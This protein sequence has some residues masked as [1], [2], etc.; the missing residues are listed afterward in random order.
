MSYKKV[1]KINPKVVI[2]KNKRKNLE[3]ASIQIN[4]IKE[5]ATVVYVDEFKY[6]CHKSGIYGWAYKGKSGN[7][8]LI[9]G[10]FQATLIAVVSAKK[11]HEVL[12]TTKTIDSQ[13]FK[14]FLCKL[15]QSIDK[16][17]VIVCDNSKVH[18]SKLIRDFLKDYKLW[19]ITIP[20][21]CPWVNAWE[22]LILNIKTW[23]RKYEREINEITLMTIKRWLDSI[24]SSEL[25]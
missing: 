10:K 12:S 23:V 7:R 8:K 5:G 20:A 15:V 13:V 25:D 14:Y 3:D 18:V 19:I 4:L 6:S 1:N 9:P 11:I 21:Y 16:N 2:N 17:Y 24:K 22:K